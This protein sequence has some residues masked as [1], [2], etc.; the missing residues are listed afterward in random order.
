MDLKENIKNYTG[1]VL[2]LLLLIIFT[3]ANTFHFCINTY[4]GRVLLIIVLLVA[5]YCNKIFGIVIVLLIIIIFNNMSLTEGM[6][7]NIETNKESSKEKSVPET[8]MDESINKNQ[9]N[10]THAIEKSSETVDPNTTNP[11]DTS[12]NRSVEGFDMIGTENSIQRG[13][14]SNSIHINQESRTFKNV[15][16]TDTD[17]LFIDNYSNF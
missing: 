17:S 14:Q 5:S 13:K 7:S 6:T 2:I 3:Q 12:K 4:L 11:K 1:V 15:S 10:I 16:G 9:E 8:E